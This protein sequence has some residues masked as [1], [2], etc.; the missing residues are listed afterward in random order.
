MT[1]DRRQSVKEPLQIPPTKHTTARCLL[2][3]GLYLVLV[4]LQKIRPYII[5]SQNLT[6]AVP[7]SD[8]LKIYILE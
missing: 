7:F 5:T 2:H 4:T 8:H 1:L 6:V 3:H